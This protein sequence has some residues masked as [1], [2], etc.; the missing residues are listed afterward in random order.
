M[1]CP[2]YFGDTLLGLFAVYHIDPDRYTEDHRRL[3][4]RVGEQAGTVLH[5][6][7]VFEQTQEDALTDLLTGLP[8]RRSMS[9]HLS[10]ELARAERSE[11]EVAVVVVDVDDFKTINDSHGHNVGDQVLREVAKALLTV[12]RSY[13]LCARY[14]G[15]EFVLVLSSCTREAAELRR[16]ELQQRVS[17]IEIEVWPETILRLSASAGV[18]V[19]PH[20]GATFESLIASADRR[21]YAQKASRGGRGRRPADA[22]AATKS[23]FVEV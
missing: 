19:F 8:N 2:L 4:E 1:V 20:D 17:E 6:A 7:I 16:M 14:A 9:V 13:D 23:A 18:S 10:Q 5:N 22:A 15:D 12:C 21:M 3:L 11:N